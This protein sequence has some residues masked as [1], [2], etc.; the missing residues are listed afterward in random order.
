MIAGLGFIFGAVRFGLWGILV[1]L[2][3]GLDILG[4]SGGDSS[5]VQE[6]GLSSMFHFDGG[7]GSERKSRIYH[8]K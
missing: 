8:G 6:M 7:R 3:A 2:A 5:C 1:I 4:E